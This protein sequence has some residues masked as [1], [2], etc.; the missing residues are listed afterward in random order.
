MDELEDADIQNSPQSDTGEK[1]SC[2]NSTLSSDCSM[3]LKNPIDLLDN[4]SG[5]RK[6]LENLII[7][8]FN[9]TSS[10]KLENISK[11]SSSDRINQS[12]EDYDDREHTPEE[13]DEDQN[14]MSD[15]SKNSSSQNID[16][17][18]ADENES[19][20]NGFKTTESVSANHFS[21]RVNE[22]DSISKLDQENDLKALNDYI[23]ANATFEFEKLVVYLENNPQISEDQIYSQAEVENQESIRKIVEA[24]RKKFPELRY[25]I[26]KSVKSAFKEKYRSSLKHF[27]INRNDS[28]NRSYHSVKNADSPFNRNV[29]FRDYKTKNLLHV[30]ESQNHCSYEPQNISPP[31]NISRDGSGFSNTQKHSISQCSDHKLYKKHKSSLYSSQSGD[32]QDSSDITKS[33]QNK[34]HSSQNLKS[35][36]QNTSTLPF[37]FSPAHLNASLSTAGTIPNIFNTSLSQ[38]KAGSALNS[39]MPL[40]DGDPNALKSQL[41]DGDFMRLAATNPLFRFSDFGSMANNPYFKNLFR[42]QTGLNGTGIP[43]PLPSPSHSTFVMN[44]LHASPSSTSSSSFAT[45][46]LTPSASTGLSPMCLSVNSLTSNT[47]SIRNNTSPQSSSSSKK[48]SSNLNS[49]G[50]S[51][52]LGHH[53]HN[54]EK[55]S[56]HSDILNNNKSQNN[57]P[58]KIQNSNDE[59]NKFNRL[60]DSNNIDSYFS[61]SS[62]LKLSNKFSK[63]SPSEVQTIKSL[64]TGYK[65]SAAFLNRS[66]EELEALIN[67]SYEA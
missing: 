38:T 50:S 52:H 24:C 66:A 55:V 12:Y 56:N 3:D 42:S 21:R 23:R 62:K 32:Q 34:N 29:S 2:N 61:A 27:S 37:N 64:I 60:T 1:N 51:N 25:K 30:N 47:Q 67:H 33:S 43:N 53:T 5:K 20:E 16:L 6:D 41:F 44:N 14:D 19:N 35:I 22:L 59:I 49:K 45:P 7:K 4:E 46:S 58:L 31:S 9:T 54:L 40:L 36:N 13:D 39:N 11:T 18:I 63:L 65:E 8:K 28:R 57:S 10:N 48:T 17:K 15:N 26:N